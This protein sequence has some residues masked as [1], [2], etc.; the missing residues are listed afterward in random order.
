MKNR[1]D[2]IALVCR[3]HCRFY[4]PGAKE[5]LSC[6]GYDFI[7]E[8]AR[9]GRIEAWREQFAGSTPPVA[10]DHVARIEAALCPA[11]VFR[12]EDCDFMSDVPGAVPC[13]GYVLL[14]RLLAA[15]DPEA[16]EWL[17]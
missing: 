2:L 7:A 1:D 5:E 8:R 16:E 9:A 11:C 12:P 10:F 13:G 4:R 15:H 3:P 17:P 14:A 6:R